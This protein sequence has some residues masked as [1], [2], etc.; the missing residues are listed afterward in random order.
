MALDQ[1]FVPAVLEINK[2]TLV[3][4]FHRALSISYAPESCQHAAH[5]I[6][7]RGQHGR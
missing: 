3:V 1:Q 5:S 4:N 6:G 7:R 2:E